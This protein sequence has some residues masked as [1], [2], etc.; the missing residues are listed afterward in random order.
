[1]KTLAT[2]AW[3]QVGLLNAMHL[4]SPHDQSAELFRL[5]CWACLYTRLIKVRFEDETGYVRIV[6]FELR[7]TKS[8]GKVRSTEPCALSTTKEVYRIDK[9][10]V[11]IGRYFCESLIPACAELYRHCPS[12]IAQLSCQGEKAL[13][14]RFFNRVNK[15]AS[16]NK[17]RTAI[18]HLLQ[19]WKKILVLYSAVQKYAVAADVPLAGID[20]RR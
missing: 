2:E 19:S 17:R 8:F 20:R 10:T 12:G 5:A 4:A 6:V 15:E 7:I 18:H 9:P 13:L 16:V 11:V 1:M 14:G 3:Q